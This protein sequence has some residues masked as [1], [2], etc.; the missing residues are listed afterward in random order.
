MER[1]LID[2]YVIGGVSFGSNK[3]NSTPSSTKLIHPFIGL[4]LT[5]FIQC[6]HTLSWGG[7]QKGMTKTPLLGSICAL[8]ALASIGH[9]SQLK[10]IEKSFVEDRNFPGGPFQFWK[11][12]SSS[13]LAVAGIVWSALFP[14]M[15]VKLSY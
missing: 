8:F 2:G 11:F 6:F 13:A 9:W 14:P 1:G 7:M 5:L 12:S 15:F 3:F 10:I 4:L